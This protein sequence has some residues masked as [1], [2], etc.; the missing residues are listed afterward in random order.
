[1][2]IRCV[3]SEGYPSYGPGCNVKCENGY[4]YAGLL[5]S[6]M[7]TEWPKELV[8]NMYKAANILVK[9]GQVESMDTNRS[10]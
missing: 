3:F 1:M 5:F 6:N 7:S 9:F 4:E 2:S 10:I 8:T